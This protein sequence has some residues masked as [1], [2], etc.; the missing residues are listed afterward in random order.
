[1]DFDSYF[2]IN[3][4]DEHGSFYGLS[5]NNGS[6]GYQTIHTLTTSAALFKFIL[7]KYLEKYK[8]SRPEYLKD[9]YIASD[10]V[11]KYTFMVLIKILQNLKGMLSFCWLVPL[12]LV[13]VHWHPC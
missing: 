12:A 7:N 1:M 3:R 10:L 5:N 8:Y 6:T 13:K 9:F 2:D 11:C 4:I